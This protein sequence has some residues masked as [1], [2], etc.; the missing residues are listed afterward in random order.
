MKI[1][2]LAALTVAPQGTIRHYESL[3]LI[4]A[5]RRFNGYREFCDCDVHKV[6]F[7][8]QAREIGFSIAQC[9]EVLELSDQP[10]VGQLEFME[11]VLTNILRV[12]EKEAELDAFRR[13]L[14]CLLKRACE[15]DRVGLSKRGA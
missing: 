10:E 1:G 12:D 7:I 3:G 13:D 6:R 4:T 15:S 14:E 8:R 11:C 2:E 5:R 9:R